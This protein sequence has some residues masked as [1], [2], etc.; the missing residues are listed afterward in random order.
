MELNTFFSVIYIPVL[1]HA[2]LVLL[3]GDVCVEPD[4]D[5][6]D[7]LLSQRT[8]GTEEWAGACKFIA[9]NGERIPQENGENRKVGLRE[10]NQTES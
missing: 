1:P 7:F 4:A 8:A 3:V 9:F 5:L 2:G 6:N 10:S